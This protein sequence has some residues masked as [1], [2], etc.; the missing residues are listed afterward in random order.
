MEEMDLS[1]IN[2]KPCPCGYQICR[3]CHHHII[4]NLNKRCPACRREYTEEGIEFTPVSPEEIKRLTALKKTKAKVNK[5]LESLGRR[6]L[7]DVR[8]I[9]KSM[10]FVVGMGVGQEGRA[11][12]QLA[13]LR[14]NDY[15][16]QYGKISKLILHKRPPSS[17]PS[18]NNLPNVGIY[19]TYLRRED[20]AR[21]IAAL[22][23]F[24]SPSVPGQV[25]RASYGTAKYC[26]NWLRNTKCENSSCM[27]LHD[28]GDERDCFTRDDLATLNHSMKDT[29]R[30]QKPMSTATSSR[31]KKLDELTDAS[32]LPRTASWGARP[33]TGLASLPPNPTLPAP[34]GSSVK[35][36]I[37]GTP[38]STRIL[39]KKNV[40]VSLASIGAST[41]SSAPSPTVSKSKTATLSKTAGPPPGLGKDSEGPGSKSASASRAGT[42][43]LSAA[44]LSV[45]SSSSGI[46][47]PKSPRPV[48]VTSPQPPPPVPAVPS[49]PSTPVVTS[50]PPPGLTLFASQPPSRQASPAPTR[51]VLVPQV[52]APISAPASTPASVSSSPKTTVAAVVT[53]TPEAPPAV[54]SLPTPAPSRP[55]SPLAVP[56]EIVPNQAIT[57]P[58]PV[59]QPLQQPS[60]PVSSE[61]VPENA[62]QS[63]I[64]QQQQQ[65]QQLPH[66]QAYHP[67][68]QTQ[69][70]VSEMTA[71]REA[72]P[73]S[74]F[75]PFPDRTSIR[76]FPHS[77]M[78]NLDSIFT[79][80]RK[81]IF[82]ETGLINPQ[83]LKNPLTHLD[84][85][86]HLPGLAVGSLRL[87]LH[88]R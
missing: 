81:P 66:Q 67:S 17:T 44:K 48:I 30:L 24:P 61:S 86:V 80:T 50:A 26:E 58:E 40:V 83:P 51:A 69:A 13:T 60:S 12:E 49:A 38:S 36:Q 45:S 28:W 9:V 8:I 63:N 88:C 22:D 7:K 10:V 76:C 37:P 33:G 27:G 3:F 4:A 42:P 2:F 46:P 18:S 71:R 29:E 82:L 73:S 74:L 21:A 41:S 70:L 47:P 5:E 55:S 16:G 87:A 25:L 20:A 52:S 84:L 31:A 14:S 79:W 32:A 64:I 6:H 59:S 23:G 35:S 39:P 72:Q 56:T 65:T 68:S 85:L 15:F 78:A 57:T 77:R 54:P 11:E 43:V 19:I 34:N 62:F 53:E 75:S 1:D